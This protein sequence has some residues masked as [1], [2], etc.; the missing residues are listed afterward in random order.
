MRHNAKVS[1]DEGGMLWV[2]FDHEGQHYHLRYD[3]YDSALPYP[4]RRD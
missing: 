1:A 3:C 2:D 4:I